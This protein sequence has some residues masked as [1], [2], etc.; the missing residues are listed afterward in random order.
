MSSDPRDPTGRSPSSGRRTPGGSQGASRGGFQ[1]TDA[2]SGASHE[3]QPNSRQGAGQPPFGGY[4]FGNDRS[5]QG[6]GWGSSTGNGGRN[7]QKATFLGLPVTL[8]YALGAAIIGIVFI[9]AVC[10]KPTATGSVAGQVKALNADRSVSTLAGA[11]IVVRGS[12]QTYTATSTDVP[13]DADGEAAYNYKIEN[14]PPGK[15]TMA[16][17]PPAGSNLQPE[18]DISFKVESGQLFPQ[19]TMLLAQGIQKPRALAQNELQPGEAGGYINDRGER[20][21]YQ[22]GGFDT[23]DALLLYLLWRNPGG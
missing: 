2:E 14:V 21:V 9:G 22:Q 17:T 11:Q 19:S 10:G 4:P 7:G 5:R 12:S 6:G 8:I 23:T 13:A 20:V 16:V 3:Y 1:P 15:Y 18:Q